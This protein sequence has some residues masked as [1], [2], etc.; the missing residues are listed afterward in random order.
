[1]SKYVTSLEKHLVFVIR[2]QQK[3][4]KNVDGRGSEIELDVSELEFMCKSITLHKH[5]ATNSVS[6][7]SRV[8]Q[9]VAS[10]SSSSQG[11]EPE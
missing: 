3:N 6:R 4:P 7:T 8:E 9:K 10:L 2:I 5:T 11:T 1:M